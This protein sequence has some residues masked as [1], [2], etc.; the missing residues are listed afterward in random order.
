MPD[1]RGGYQLGETIAPSASLIERDPEAAC[2]NSFW[3]PP[4]ALLYRRELVDRIAWHPRLP[5][6][7]DARFLFDAAAIGARF[8]HV[9]GVGA[10][11]RVAPDSL[12]RGKRPQFIR[13]CFINAE[14]IER[15]WRRRGVLCKARQEALTEMWIYVAIAS[16]REG[17]PEF[18]AARRAHNRLSSRRAL[19]EAMCVSRTLLG[20]SRARNLEHAIRKLQSWF[21]RVHHYSPTHTRKSVI[22]S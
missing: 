10:Y 4:A 1:G 13:D 14:E 12:S 3:A 16:F 2:A 20:A 19:I 6:I 7:Q 22:S 5:V 21:E 15:S 11:Y 8:I 18:S 9:P 17:M